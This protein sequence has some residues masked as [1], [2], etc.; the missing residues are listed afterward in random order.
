MPLDYPA[1]LS[2]REEGYRTQY[3]DRDTMLYALG[4]GMGADPLNAAELPFVYEKDLRAVPSLATVISWGA[5]I[6]TDKLGLDHHLV[7]HGEEEI[8]FHRP[9]P[10][11]AAIIADWAV[12]RVYDKGRD[13]GALVV[14]QTVI[15]SAA[16]REP[17][18]T[19][20]RTLFARGDGGCGGSTEPPPMP[21]AVPTR[22]AD[23]SVDIATRPDQGALYRLCGDRNP[24]HID[25]EA[26]KLAGFDGPILHGL[27]TYGLSCRAVL[28]TICEYDPSRII[29]HSA[30][31][32]APVYPGDTVRIDIWKDGDAASFE[33]SV[34]SRGVTVIRNGRTLLRPDA[35]G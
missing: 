30:R 34:P 17:L 32:S 15:R 3:G 8:I 33:A 7:L 22:A 19:I 28:Q 11:A 25:P 2:L 6:S 13:K 23:F 29:H 24:L 18:C 9:L 27:C 1:I 21:H 12:S 26:A 16:D 20:N 5:G 14:L 10:P 31:F 35:D 4:I